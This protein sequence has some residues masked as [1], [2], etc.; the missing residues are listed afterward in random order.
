ME[1]LEN[2]YKNLCLTKYRE[3]QNKIYFD[4]WVFRKEI[5]KQARSNQI[6]NKIENEKRSVMEEK[7]KYLSNLLS[8]ED[9]MEDKIIQGNGLL[10]IFQL[11]KIY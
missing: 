1:K 4:N 5:D 10:V 7:K 2:E 6:K 9:W 11:L 8:V 3:E